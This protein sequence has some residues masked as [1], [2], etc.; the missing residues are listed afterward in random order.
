MARTPSPYRTNNNLT[1]LLILEQAKRVTTANDGSRPSIKQL[2]EELALH[3]G[4]QADTIN[5]LRRNKTQ[6]SLQVALKICE[7]LGQPVEKVF[8][9]IDNPDY[10]Q[11]LEQEAVYV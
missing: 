2:E 3:C 7:Y 9:I 5:L 10:E 4:V 6:A 1:K 11:E 8:Y